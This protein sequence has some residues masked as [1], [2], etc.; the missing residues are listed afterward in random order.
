MRRK[1]LFWRIHTIH[2]KVIPVMFLKRLM[3]FVYRGELP[4]YSGV[5]IYLVTQ[6]YM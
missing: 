3:P 2:T 1:V 5:A 4:Y 6:D